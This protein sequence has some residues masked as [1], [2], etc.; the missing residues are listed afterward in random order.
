MLA[1]GAKDFEHRILY[2]YNKELTFQISC[3]CKREGF[4]KG[5][6]FSIVFG[7]TSF[8]SNT[9]PFI[10]HSPQNPKPVKTINFSPRKGSNEVICT[11]SIYSPQDGSATL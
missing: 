11:H 6:Q 4:Q 7:V 5:Y 2:G 9:S 1:N 10:P 8:F 3:I